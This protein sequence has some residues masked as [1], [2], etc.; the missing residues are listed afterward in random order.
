MPD[1]VFAAIEPGV[2]ARALATDAAAAFR[3]A[4]T[5]WAGEKFVASAP[6]HVTLSFFGA[7]PDPELPELLS[8]LTNLCAATSPFSLRLDHLRCVPSARRAAM[9]W[10]SLTGDTGDAAALAA[11]IAESAGIS[12]DARGFRPHMTI[13]RA[14]RPRPVSQDAAAAADSALSAPGREADRIVSVPTVTVFASTL[15]PAGPTY[16]C[17]AVLPLAGGR[18]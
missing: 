17:L 5:S 11:G 15:G 4:D 12:V 16:E 7:V 8:K 10:L 9:L 2:A 14:R 13:A 18:G 6:L 1:R 3:G